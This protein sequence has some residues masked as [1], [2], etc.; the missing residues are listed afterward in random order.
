MKCCKVWEIDGIFLKKYC[1]FR[2]RIK[3]KKY[4]VYRWGFDFECT[5][6]SGH[7]PYQYEFEGE[8]E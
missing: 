5:A 8:V 2:K 6:Q 4:S 1:N 7:C 3:N